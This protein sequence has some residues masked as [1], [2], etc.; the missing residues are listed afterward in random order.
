MAASVGTKPGSMPDG[1]GV[2]AAVLLAD[3]LGDGDASGEGDPLGV[4]VGV[5]FAAAVE[6]HPPR[7]IAMAMAAQPVPRR[8][9]RVPPDMHIGRRPCFGHARSE[10]GAPWPEAARGRGDKKL[11]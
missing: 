5:G 3:G 8:R 7:T 4:A 2:G 10:G 6:V 11:L 1:V 9:D